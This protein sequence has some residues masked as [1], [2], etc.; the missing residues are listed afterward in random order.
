MFSLSFSF[1]LFC[2]SPVLPHL[3]SIHSRTLHIIVSLSVHILM[4]CSH[5][6]IPITNA[7]SVVWAPDSPIFFF[8]IQSFIIFSFQHSGFH[9]TWLF[10]SYA[11]FAIAFPSHVSPPLCTTSFLQ[12]YWGTKDITYKLPYSSNSSWL[13]THFDPN[14]QS[15]T[16][17]NNAFFINIT[18]FHLTFP[19]LSSGDLIFTSVMKDES[20]SSTFECLYFCITS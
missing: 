19:V 7:F 10:L 3:P 17:F 11:F 5:T 15:L 20:S 14:M 16:K 18:H 1:D 6:L 2:C 9:S 13:L 4:L 12:L 8:N